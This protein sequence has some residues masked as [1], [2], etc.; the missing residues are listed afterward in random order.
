MPAAC[1]DSFGFGTPFV[2][3]NQQNGFAAATGGGI[4]GSACFPAVNTNTW[5]D[6][7]GNLLP[8]A[9]SNPTKCS[10]LGAKGPVSG[11][12]YFGG[13]FIPDGKPD[14]YKDPK[15]EYEAVE[16]E[17]RKAFTHNWA[18]SV[19][20]RV[21][22]LRG[23]YEGAFRNDNNQAD[24]GISSLFDFTEGALGLLANQQSIGSLST[25][26]KQVLN[27]HSTFVVPNGKLK[28][29]VIGGGVSVLSGNPL[30]S[31]YAQQAYQN[32]GEVPLFGRGN[33]GRSQ[34]NGSV[35]A[36]LEYPFKLTERMQLKVGFDLFNIV[37]STRQTT[38]NQFGDLGFSLNNRDFQKAVTNNG[39]VTPASFVSQGFVNPFSSRLSVLFTF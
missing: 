35:D 6:A 2:A 17:V 16:F 3:Y 4:A 38:V 27:A 36:H 20:Y 22:Q 19:N 29:F 34:V 12:A 37:D 18:L 1:F 10:P 15:R 9:V 14:T 33:L 5:T 11:C 32:A 7:S 30:T 8:N 25:D 39:A 13:E 28:G 24:P 21:A 31:L 23:N 26:R